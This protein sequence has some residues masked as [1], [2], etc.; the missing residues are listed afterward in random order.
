MGSISGILSSRA[1]R[2]L[3]HTANRLA[4]GLRGNRPADTAMY[5]LSEVANHSVLWHGINAVDAIVG[6]PQHRKAALRRSVILAAEQA[7]VNGVVKS[8]VGRN[9]PASDV[10]SPHRLRKPR[11]SSFPSGHASAGAC[12]A[13]LLAQDLGGAPIWWTAA[14]T[15]SWSRIHVRV[16]Y[17]SDILAGLIV[18]RTLALA[19]SK[20]WPINSEDNPYG[21]LLDAN[22]Q[23][24][25][26]LANGST[27]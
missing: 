7:L 12:A 19:A 8:L 27:N 24:V 9:R 16:H 21:N 3:D 5:A 1:V 6:G 15:V 20:L 17:M 4:D 26:P 23:L 2:S 18:G 14:L 13:T 11:T 10:V 25:D 22:A